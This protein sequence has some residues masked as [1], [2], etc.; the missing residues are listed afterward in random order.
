MYV[1]M[2]DF[3]SQCIT[4][5]GSS[6]D[7]KVIEGGRERERERESFSN[8]FCPYHSLFIKYSLQK[9]RPVQGGGGGPGYPAKY[10]HVTLLPE[11]CPQCYL[12]IKFQCYL[13]TC[14]IC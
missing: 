12:Q 10:A 14:Q 13:V 8:Q 1:F 7:G 3:E 2:V 4:H 5:C 11:N 6:R 9:V